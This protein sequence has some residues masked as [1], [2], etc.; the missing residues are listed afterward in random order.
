[1]KENRIIE[2]L[3]PQRIKAVA[4]NIGNVR[5]LLWEKAPQI[6][7]NE[8]E[9]AEI[10]GGG[11]LIL[12]FGRELSGGIRILTYK[13]EG[14][15]KV[16]LRFGESLTETCSEPKGT[17]EGATAT[18]DHSLRDF[19]VKLVSLSDM[20]FGNTGFR[21]VRLDFPSNCKIKLK[22]IFA[23]FEHRDL[24][25][26]GRFECSDS[27]VNR[28]FDTAAYTVELCIQSMLWDGIK[29]DRLVWVGD[30]HPE[31]L[32]VV[33]LFGEDPCVEQALAFAR[34]ETPLPAFMNNIP[35]YSFWW[36]V[37]IADYYLHN[38]NIAFLEQEGDY[39]KSLVCQIDALVEKDGSMRLSRYFLDWP[40]ADTEGRAGT[41]ALCAYAMR[42]AKIIYRA[43]KED[44][45][46]LDG[47]LH[48]IECTLKGGAFKQV[49]AMRVLAG[50]DKAEDVVGCLIGNGA[51]GMSTFMSYY[52]LSSVAM[53]GRT[54]EALQMMREYYG[55]MLERGATT[56]WED[57]DISWLNDSGRIDEFP[58]EGQKDI[59]G[60]F[61]AYC[62]KGFRHSLCHGW[63]SGPVPFLM[64][65]VLG[66]REVEAGCKKVIFEPELC[67]LKWAEGS[68]PTP[69]GNIEISLREINGETKAEIKAPSEIEIV[70]RRE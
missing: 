33:S 59:H 45:T 54:K 48:R 37:I 15:A 29:R 12:D 40:T 43:L 27:T 23:A 63:S 5:S 39:I 46:V 3:M 6:G 64:H 16:R 24:K 42:K 49:T 69:Y 9:Y 8:T 47:I 44:C 20:R 10:D 26:L 68:Y 2:Y 38:G 34:E 18:N 32:A 67:G 19:E 4:G 60:D 14:N 30:M 70:R 62:Y 65:Y 11:Y 61:G 53:A 22:N 58:K 36:L 17:R 31:T 25:R 13:A 56:F 28:I 7:L 57:F 1:M 41:Y 52:I 66:V 35:S 51:R 55:G 21:F 50:F